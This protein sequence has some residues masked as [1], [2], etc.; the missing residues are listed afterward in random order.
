MSSPLYTEEEYR[1]NVGEKSLPR[2]L[3]WP[4]RA[5]E[6]RIRKLLYGMAGEYARV[7]TQVQKLLVESDPRTTTELLSDFEREYGLPGDCGGLGATVQLRRNALVAKITDPGGY[8]PDD[9]IAR[10]AA[11]GFSITLTE[12]TP[13][14]CG[15]SRCGDP[16]LGAA[17]WYALGIN[18][19]LETVQAATVGG[20]AC[21]DPLRFWG[22]D[23]LECYLGDFAQGQVTLI[24]FYS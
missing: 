20:S 6:S 17:W 14:R 5:L 3:A 13:A 11:I 22:N 18:A 23:T 1:D 10:A 2:G 8:H 15:V 4:I 7:D 16:M 9:Y 12:F 21:G 24:F 19:P